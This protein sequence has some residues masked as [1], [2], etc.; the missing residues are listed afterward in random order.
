MPLSNVTV[1]C[2]GGDNKIEETVFWCTGM[3]NHQNQ[4]VAC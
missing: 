1:I 2:A 4:A 3:E